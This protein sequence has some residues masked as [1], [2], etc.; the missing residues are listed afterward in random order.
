[1]TQR[2]EQLEQQHDNNAAAANI[3]NGMIEKGEVLQDI[4]GNYVVKSGSNMSSL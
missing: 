3:L 2:V 1:M 4:T